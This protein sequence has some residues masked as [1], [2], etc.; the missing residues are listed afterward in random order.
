MMGNKKR[1]PS[2]QKGLCWGEE[3][4][5]KRRLLKLNPGSFEG[6]KAKSGG[7]VF[8]REGGDVQIGGGEGARSWEGD[9]SSTGPQQ[10]N[11]RSEKRHKIMRRCGEGNFGRARTGTW[12]GTASPKNK[13]AWGKGH[14]EAE[15]RRNQKSGTKKI[16]CHQDGIRP[17]PCP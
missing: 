6:N 3:R 10:L 11:W 14:N 1:G 5:K 13:T 17:T 9:K 16:R 8:Q 15:G 12:V 7:E 4:G 2:S